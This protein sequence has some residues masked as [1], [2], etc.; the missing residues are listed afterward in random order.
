[1]NADEVVQRLV[2]VVSDDIRLAGLVLYT[3][4]FEGAH[5]QR[6]GGMILAGRFWRETG[7]TG[8]SSARER[9]RECSEAA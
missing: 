1:M 6:V 2:L 4:V 8:G 9:H 5:L 7:G 3:V